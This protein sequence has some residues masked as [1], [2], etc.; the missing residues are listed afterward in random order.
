MSALIAG[1]PDLFAIG[2]LASFS[3]G[4]DRP[5]PAVAP[6]AMQQGQY[7]ARLIRARLQGR[8]TPP[9]R[10]LN[11]G[12]LAVIG[13]NA[14]VAHIGRIKSGGLFAWLLWVFVHIYYL[15]GFDQKVLVMFRWVWNYVT[16]KRGAR[17]ITES[18]PAHASNH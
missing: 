8:R 6:V 15:I 12:N 18:P 16:R 7:V 10:Y 17:L 2:D 13:R 11:K 4:L 3:H 14:A 9:F 1:H 5:L